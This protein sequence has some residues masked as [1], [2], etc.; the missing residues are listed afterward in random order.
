MRS[1]PLHDQWPFVLGT[2]NTHP[3]VFLPR[4]IQG[5]FGLLRKDLILFAVV[6]STGL[7]A[8]G[9]RVYIKHVF[10]CYKESSLHHKCLCILAHLIRNISLSRQHN[11]V[12][13]STRTRKQRAKVS[14]AQV[15]Q[16]FALSFPNLQQ[17]AALLLKVFFTPSSPGSNVQQTSF[18][19][20]CGRYSTVYWCSYPPAIFSVCGLTSGRGALTRHLEHVQ[21][22]QLNSCRYFKLLSL[23][24][25][26]LDEVLL[27][28]RVLHVN[29]PLVLRE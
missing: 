21:Q 3:H 5:L 16:C 15:L 19:D 14:F 10:V 2:D 8:P 29:L 13:C 22:Q 1:D 11:N 4:R 6:R 28:A 23:N 17:V 26:L 12:S 9:L 7:G 20:S 24:R 18:N 27:N 25:S